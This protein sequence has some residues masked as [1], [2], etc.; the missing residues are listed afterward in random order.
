LATASVGQNSC[1]SK[2]RAANTNMLRK[3]ACG[4][5]IGT[6]MAGASAQTN[7]Q[8]NPESGAYMHDGRGTILRSEHGLCWRN[9]FWAQTD[10]VA[11]CDGELIPPISKPT[12]PAIVQ[13]TA[14][15]AAA[16]PAPT[17]VL[18]VAVKRCDFAIT[19]DSDQAFAFNQAALSTTARKRIDDEALSRLASC[20]RVDLLLVTAHTDQRGSEQYNQKLS[21]QRADTV[22]TYLKS[23]VAA[24]QIDTHGAGEAQPVKACNGNLT[25][26]RLVKCMAPNR[27]VTIEARGIAK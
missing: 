19:L 23:K 10:A 11:G 14:A 22:A 25:R 2:T 6:A 17:P 21:E 7:I 1:F 12:A 5:V 27:R 15:T 3:M 8:A 18:P 24:A 20:A 4:L 13:P 16:A 26:A 9:G